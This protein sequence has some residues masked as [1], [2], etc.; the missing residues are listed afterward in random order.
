[1]LQEIVMKEKEKS[2]IDNPK[3]CAQ[4][5]IVMCLR[6]NYETKSCSAASS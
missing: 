3:F 4:A 5:F 2:R 1:M 6:E